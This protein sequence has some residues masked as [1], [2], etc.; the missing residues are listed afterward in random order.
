MKINQ[1]PNFGH[2]NSSVRPGAIEYIV[3]HYVG[4][5]G[6]AK[7]NINYYNQPSVTNASADFYV[8]HT[9]DIWQYNP[10][11]RKRYCY[12]VGGGRKSSYGGS[13]YGIAKNANCVNV[14]MCVKTRGGKTA[15]SPDWYFTDATIVSTVALVKYLMNLYGIPA[16]RVIRH[17]DVNGKYCPGVVGWN[18][19][20]GSES[21]WNSFK[22]AISGGST[23]SVTPAPAPAAGETY[24]V[25]KS[26]SD[27]NS[28][29]GAYTVLENAI[30]VAK[31]NQGY[32]VYDSKGNCVYSPGGSV[33]FSVRVKIEDLNI[34]K[35]PGTN[36]K[37]AGY[38]EPGT[39]TIVEVKSGKGSSKG[40]GRL[41]SGAGWISL[42][43]A[44][45]V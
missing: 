8:G 26:W 7:N 24:R 41:K 1:N 43:Y 4:A 15:N 2:H 21:A 6:D 35:G 37:K 36:Y 22:A 30:G 16:S 39:Y 17:Y 33:A 45:R 19:P 5:T 29:I 38:I 10:D 9:G 13:L 25:R 44:E 11:P 3:V 34:R 32:N 40:W 42:N 28:Q 23:P 27:S 18:A 14:E 31:K 12:A 20:S